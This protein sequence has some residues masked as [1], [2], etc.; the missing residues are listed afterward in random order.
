ML[1]ILRDPTLVGM[2]RSTEILFRFE[3]FDYDAC[4][5][6]HVGTSKRLFIIR[7][8]GLNVLI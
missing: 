1:I 8:L 4:M 6:K 2:L 7:K 5:Y 3:Y